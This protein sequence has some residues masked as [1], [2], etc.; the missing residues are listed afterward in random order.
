MEGW[1]GSLSKLSRHPR[2]IGNGMRW[3]SLD[4]MLNPEVVLQTANSK[5]CLQ[6]KAYQL[7]QW[8]DTSHISPS[9]SSVIHLSTPCALLDQQ[10]SFELCHQSLNLLVTA[11]NSK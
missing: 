2:L 4:G 3:V 11:Q 1:K 9:L 10:C 7:A 6:P 5:E 8:S